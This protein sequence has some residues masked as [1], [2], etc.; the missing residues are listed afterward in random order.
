MNDKKKMMVVG[1]L[2]A[3][4]LAVG[5]FQFMSPAPGIV[6]EGGSDASDPVAANPTP[7]DPAAP[8]KD[9][10]RE[11]LISLATGT[12]TPRD[13]FVPSG[14]LL[15]EF[16]NPLTKTPPASEAPRP[17][18]P[19]PSGP[20]RSYSESI[21]PLRPMPGDLR[22]TA[23]DGQGI[24]GPI[25]TS[26]PTPGQQ[27]YQ[28]FGYKVKGVIVGTKRMV[29]LEDSNGSQKLVAEGSSVDG[30]TT[31]VGIEGSRVHIRQRGRKTEVKLQEDNR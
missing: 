15:A 22:P 29:V 14:E 17:Q 6:D 10:V 23:P 24:S 13:P 25:A 12:A 2:V 16:Q 20:R 26:L 28:E 8:K 1:A 9:P 4:L 27:N 7:V 18:A 11:M 19:T 30:D 21:E 31:I 3:A 5:A